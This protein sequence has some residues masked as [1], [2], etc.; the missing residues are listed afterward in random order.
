[1]SN[2]AERLNAAAGGVTRRLRQWWLA[3]RGVEIG[4]ECWIQN[5]MVPRN[6][7]DIRLGT[8]VMLDRQVVLIATGERRDTPRIQIE[9]DVYINRFSVIDA[10]H[11]V[12][13]GADTM[14]GPHCYITDHDHGMRPGELI[15]NQP[16]RGR[17][18]SI[19]R[20]CWI[21]AGATLLKGVQIGDGAVVAAGAVVTSDVEANVICGGIPARPIRH[22]TA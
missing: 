6:P 15:K 9:N 17:P 11:S 12:V 7:W 2:W 5:I 14:I 22:R 4:P 18:V 19:G 8:G 3:Q 1:M 13:I 16:L 21:G 20:D 10:T